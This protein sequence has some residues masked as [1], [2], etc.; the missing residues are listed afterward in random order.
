M[1]AVVMRTAGATMAWIAL[2]ALGLTEPPYE[3]VPAMPSVFPLEAG[4]A[5]L[6]R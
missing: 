4:A 1:A 5:A 6:R 3:F 2:M